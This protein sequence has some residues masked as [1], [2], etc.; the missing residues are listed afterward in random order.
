MP[1]RLA[2]QNAEP[3]FDL[4]EPGRVER[5]KFET[6]PAPLYLEPRLNLGGRISQPSLPGVE[7]SGHCTS[8]SRGMNGADDADIV[9]QVEGMK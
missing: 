6:H 5:E 2:F 1:E 9:W 4:L 8:M 3:Q 7:F